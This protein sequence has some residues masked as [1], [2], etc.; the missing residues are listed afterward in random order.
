MSKKIVIIDDDPDIVESM[1]I[2]LDKE[3]YNVITAFNG[4]DGLEKIRASKPNLVLLD[5]M[6]TSKDEGFQVSYAMKA[7]PALKDIP[8]VMITSVAQMTGFEFDKKK[9]GDFIPADE[10]VEKP[11]KPKQLIEIVRKNLGA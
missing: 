9:D 4:K 11:V 7:D 3:G 1:K 2:V 8:I 5:I 10:Y 6:M